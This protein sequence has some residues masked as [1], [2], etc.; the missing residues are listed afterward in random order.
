MEST[1]L[2]QMPEGSD[3]V[4]RKAAAVA[5]VAFG[6]TL[7]CTYVNTPMK[8]DTWDVS[9]EQHGLGVLPLLVAF[10]ALGSAVVFGVAV[11]RAAARPAERTGPSALLLAVL[12][13]A[14]TVVFWTGLPVVLA[15]G[16]VFLARSSRVR[17]GRWSPSAGAAAVLAAVTLL[18]EGWLAFTG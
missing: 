16:A 2:T 1:K 5:A 7:I 10:A 15:A 18:M 17:T 3:N 8:G 12:G 4:M 6:V 9:A 14:T 13:A 11:R